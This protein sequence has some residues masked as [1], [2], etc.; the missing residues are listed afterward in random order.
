M[1]NGSMIRKHDLAYRLVIIPL[2]KR[3]S[4]SKD[5]PLLSSN[6]VLDHESFYNSFT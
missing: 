4:E 1:L 3:V 2:M 6:A 5:N